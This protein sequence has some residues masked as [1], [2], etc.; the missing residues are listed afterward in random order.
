MMEESGKYLTAYNFPVMKMWF[1]MKIRQMTPVLLSTVFLAMLLF[2]PQQC[3]AGAA[4]GLKNCAE[5]LIPSLFPYMFLSSFLM[6]SGAAEKAGRFLAPVTRRIFGLPPVCSAAIIMSMIGG[7]PVGA[8][9]VQILYSDGKITETQAKKMMQ[10]CVC[11]GPAFMITAVGT[12]MLH[13]KEAGIILYISQ[14]ISCIFLGILSGRK[15][16][17]DKNN[18]TNRL[19][20]PALKHSGTAILITQASEDASRS[21]LGMTALVVLFSV[22]IQTVSDVGIFSR[23]ANLIS[24]MG[25][26]Q[27]ITETLP[28]ILLE[29][30][31][32]CNAVRQAGLPLWWYAAAVGFG[33]L[34]VHFQILSILQG[35]PVRFGKYLLYRFLNAVLSSLIVYGICCFYTPTN[36]VFSVFGGHEADF[37]AVSTTGSIALM[38]LCGVFVL[39]MQ[40]KTLR[41]RF[42]T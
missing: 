4:K 25:I 35:L 17:C 30:T 38:V 26:P 3:A 29:V 15:N 31:A 11:S 20:P 5:I 22:V 39:S 12:M 42:F 28:S 19:S 34:C 1:S 7:F 13:N 2:F 18:D 27:R 40:K 41:R 32:A 8:K 10:F 23:I 14:I 9:C 21:M 37:S 33:G 6:R 24:N 16:K 36:S